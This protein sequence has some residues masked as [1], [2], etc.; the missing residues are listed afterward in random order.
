MDLTAVFRELLAHHDYVSL[1]GLG[2]F[3]RHYEPA[4]LADGGRCLRPPCERYAFDP[5][6]TFDDNA[7][8]HHLQESMGLSAQEADEQVRAFVDRVTIGLSA[9]EAVQ[10]AGLGVLRPKAD[11]SIA[12]ETDEAQE[13]ATFGLPNLAVEPRVASVAPAA[14]VAAPVSAV[15]ASVAPAAKPAP[16]AV[17]V[18]PAPKPT[19]KPTPK[20]APSAAPDDGRRGRWVGI[21][22]ALL[23]VAA[24]AL[25]VLLYS[26]WRP[27]DTHQTTVPSSPVAT[28]APIDTAASSA[29]PPV[30]IST[31]PKTALHYAEAQATDDQR[32]HYIVVGSYSQKDN[33][34]KQMRSLEAQGYRPTLLQDGPN[35]RVA[36]YRF[37]NRDRAL[38]EL[39]RLRA[40]NVSSKVWLYSM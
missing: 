20:P 18:T 27:W 9:G 23:A 32:E 22:A 7:L 29:A 25:L 35:Y 34:T 17:I 14:S 5:Q 11:G 36:L 24:I 37:T 10:F 4:S 16:A 30:R 40:Q 8:V 6:R 3:V 21:A 2:S 1:P 12:L 31:D 39:E 19:P 38:R 15:A 13:T 33:A 26:P 28:T